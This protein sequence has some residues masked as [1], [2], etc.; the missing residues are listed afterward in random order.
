MLF[1]AVYIVLQQSQQYSKLYAILNTSICPIFI[2][3]NSYIPSISF[4]VPIGILFS[5]RSSDLNTTD[6]F[7]KPL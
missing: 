4:S 2:L 7:I 1:Y 5:S 6:M 3:Y